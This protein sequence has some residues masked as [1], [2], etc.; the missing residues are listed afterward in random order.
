MTRL[1][2]TQATQTKIVSVPVAPAGK[3][4]AISNLLVA[5]KANDV[6]AAMESVQGRLTPSQSRVVML[7]NGMGYSTGKAVEQQLVASS[8][9]G[10]FMRERFNVVHT[11]FGEVHIGPAPGATV[12]PG[13]LA[14]V[15]LEL[16][17]AGLAVS[18]VDDMLPLLWRKLAA[19]AALN[20]ATALVGCKNGAMVE[21]SEGRRFVELICHEVSA[22][23]VGGLTG[24]ELTEYALEVARSSA[25][26]YSSMYQDMVHGRPT[27]IDYINGH[28]VRCSH[29][30]G[31]Q[32][33]T[34]Q[35]VLSLVK[36]KEQM[37]MERRKH[38]R[39]QD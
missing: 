18:A 24:E 4:G 14:T 31:V 34:N 7:C 35:A 1:S 12:D 19:N 27:E 21:S 39:A 9:H 13:A 5:T 8:T 28:V 16:Q 29:S 11:G 22:V 3:A 25:E 26:N 36:L 2:C 38:H 17:I 37:S 32:A 20:G 6:A 10:C 15:A 33:A 30:K 23:M